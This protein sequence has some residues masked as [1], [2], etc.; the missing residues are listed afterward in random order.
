[1]RAGYDFML[2][3]GAPSN[4]RPNMVLPFVLEYFEKLNAIAMLEAGRSP[5]KA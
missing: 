2:P 3:S 1:M 4:A 5:S